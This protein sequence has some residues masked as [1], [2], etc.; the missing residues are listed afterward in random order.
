LASIRSDYDQQLVDE[1]LLNRWIC[2]LFSAN[3]KVYGKIIKD[4]SFFYESFNCF[5][6]AEEEGNFID[7]SLFFV[8]K[9]RLEKF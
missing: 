2:K 4:D 8:D 6:L 3:G 5:P 9:L 7:F 1:M